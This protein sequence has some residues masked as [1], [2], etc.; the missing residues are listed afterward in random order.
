M[1]ETAGLEKISEAVEGLLPGE[2]ELV[3]ARFSGG[4][5]LTILVDRT[6]GPVD[7][8]FC[9]RVVS[10]VSPALES[11]G[12]DGMIEVSSP[13]IER[14]LTR[15]DH[16]RRFIGR[17]AKIKVAEPIDGRRNF[18]GTIER[19]GDEEFTLKLSE[20]ESEVELPFGSVVRANL[21][22]DI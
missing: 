21:K 13:G 14:P 12:Y 9:S 6:D 16:F 20:G 3:D 10:A 4:P 19:A 18:T 15:P 7:H 22:E 8:E 2:A 11:E 5:L 17:E 1:R